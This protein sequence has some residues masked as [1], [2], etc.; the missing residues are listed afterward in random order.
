MTVLSVAFSQVSGRV[1]GSGLNNENRQYLNPKSPLKASFIILHV[2]PL[3][4]F[5]WRSEW[6]QFESEN[7]IIPILRV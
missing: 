4:R 5:T 6:K 7:R 3:I 1:S 2:S